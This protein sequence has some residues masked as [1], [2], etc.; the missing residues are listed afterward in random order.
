MGIQVGDILGDYQVTGI[1]GRGGMGKVYRVRSLLTERE[2]AMKVVLPDLDEDPA[3]ADRFLREIK[4]HA[5][6]QHPNI[7]ALRTALRIE[8]RLVMILE[9]VEGISLQEKLRDG[10]IDVPAAVSYSAQVLSA[11]AF[12]HERGVIH[13]DVKP[14]NILIA[15]GGVAKLTDFGIARSS[16]AARLT[17]AGLAVGTL[18]Y[19]SPEQIRSGQADA[20][21]DIYSLGLTLY[22]MVTGR[23]AMEAATE[24]ALM[25]AQLNTIPL[26]PAV[27]NAAIPHAVSAAVMRALLKDPDHR[28]QTAGEF[29][30][31]LEH[32]RQ[33]QSSSSPS[34]SRAL[35]PE[36][37]ELETRLS[38]AIG[39]IARRLVS[40]AARRHGSIS[41]IRRALAA[42]IDDP[43]A[44]AEFLKTGSST[45][46][47]TRLVATPAPAAFDRATL[48]HMAR[49]LAPYLGPIATVLVNRAARTA[50]S[51]EE[52]QNKVA[53]EI[54]SAED[55]RRFL[56]AVR[57]AL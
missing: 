18:A 45:T 15:T 40:D 26:E 22:E 10:P 24:H 8:G 44:R 6:L 16:S 33:S 23:R 14:A 42:Q 52:L 55:R 29:A 43:K 20:R 37:A 47:A 36:L 41:E 9:L 13:R 50:R 2:E 57:S 27:V 32:P 5:S 49:A 3:L 38:R 35:E 4:V 21:S 30:A 51:A 28:F 17:G 56:T 25:N 31:A 54:E 19:M 48:D 34:A 7:A 11:L 12:A 46:V 39:P 1:L 53:A